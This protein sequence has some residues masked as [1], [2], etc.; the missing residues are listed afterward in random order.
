MN[1][2]SDLVAL[3]EAIN[4]ATANA[5]WCAHIANK[6]EDFEATNW[7]DYEALSLVPA[8]LLNSVSAIDDLAID[9]YAA[10][11]FKHTPDAPELSV[12]GIVS[13]INKLR[14]EVKE[15]AKAILESLDAGEYPCAGDLDLLQVEVSEMYEQAIR[16]STLQTS[17]RRAHKLPMY[18]KRAINI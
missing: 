1:T 10:L 9:L 5:E 14:D 3:Q 7:L 2:N 17:H 8:G 15:S 12:A 18:H 13:K 6:V 4:D 11:P 16:L